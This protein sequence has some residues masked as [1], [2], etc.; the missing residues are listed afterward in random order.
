[1]NDRRNSK[2]TPAARNLRGYTALPWL[3]SL[4]CEDYPS[5]FCGA[6]ITS[7][8]NGRRVRRR[9]DGAASVFIARVARET[10]EN[11]AAPVSVTRGDK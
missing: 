1:M 11:S 2:L 9:E 8:D 4:H 3:I 6:K 7:P 10:R 5:D